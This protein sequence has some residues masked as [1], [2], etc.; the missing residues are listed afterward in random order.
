LSD[1]FAIIS[2]DEID[3]EGQ[4]EEYI[5]LRLRTT[6]GI[7]LET[8]KKLF[9]VNFK[10]KY[11]DVLKKLEYCLDVD[12]KNVKIKYEYLFVQNSIIIEFYK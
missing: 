10:E 9:G 12:E 3:L 4:E 7:D 6:Q 1:N 8:Y 5:M 2:R 11:A